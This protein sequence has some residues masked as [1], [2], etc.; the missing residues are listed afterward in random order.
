[1]TNPR[2]NGSLPRPELARGA[3]NLDENAAATRAVA[4]VPAERSPHGGLD[5]LCGEGVAHQGRPGLRR[6]LRSRTGLATLGLVALAGL[7][8]VVDHWAHLFGALPY[9]LVLACPLLHL[10]GH[11]GHGGHAASQRYR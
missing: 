11:G 9:L 10:F 1:M 5:T 7:L 2:Q 6:W 4:E 3:D 8:L